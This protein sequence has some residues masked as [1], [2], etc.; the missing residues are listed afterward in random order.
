VAFAVV[1]PGSV[2]VALAEGLRDGGG[3]R[4]PFELCPGMYPTTEEK[5]GKPQ[6][7]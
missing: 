5:D 1:E 6:S 3:G 2:G 4:A 7:V